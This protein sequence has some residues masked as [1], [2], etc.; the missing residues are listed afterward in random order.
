MKQIRH[1][2]QRE[3]ILNY[4]RCHH[5]HPTAEDVY[6]AVRKE[7]PNISLGT[8]YRNLAL[9]QELGQIRS[10]SNG[11]SAERFD[12]DL[13]D[14]H[15]LIC[16]CCNEVFDIHL[17]SSQSAGLTQVPFDGTVSGYDIIFH[18]ICKKCSEK[19]A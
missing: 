16:D 7:M 13:S 14:H 3:A 4:L 2:R 17:D 10:I 15:H 12:G 6:E 1:S 5:S 9:L 11:T 8:V 18:G 19:S